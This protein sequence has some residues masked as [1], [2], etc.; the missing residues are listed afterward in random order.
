MICQEA[1]LGC[2]G[3]WEKITWGCRGLPKCRGRPSG[4]W[5]GGKISRGGERGA[6]RCLRHPVRGA[7]ALAEA[8][9]P[10]GGA[11]GRCECRVS[12]LAAHGRSLLQE[13]VTSLARRAGQQEH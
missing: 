2:P 6:A 13:E 1:K 4:V 8:L 9:G 7:H 10:S 11:D 5:S 3:L 12:R